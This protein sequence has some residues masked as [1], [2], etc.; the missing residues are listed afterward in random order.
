MRAAL[1]ISL[2][3]IAACG[4]SGV[5]A[6]GAL[7]LPVNSQA[8]S[9]ASATVKTSPDGGIYVNPDHLDVVMVA[10]RSLH[11]LS[12]VFATPPPGEWSALQ[13]LGDFTLVAV[14]LRD[15]GK[16]GSDPALND[17]QL[18]SDYAPAGTASGALR[19]FYHPMY[20]LAVVSDRRVADDCS[21]HIDPGQVATAV[22]VFPPVRSTPDVVFG[23][24]QDF[25]LDVAFG[26]A[27]P[28][29][30]QTWYAA[31]CTP[32]PAPPSP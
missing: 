12:S 17:S 2:L 26:G 21:V 30:P 4:S 23:R 32:P 9:L 27:L 1:L 22:V 19:H 15:D 18:A 5:A 13:P 10:H 28:V 31:P 7:S 24:Y 8:A 25:A 16:A 29:Q 14:R 11:D 3:A 6:T 20:A